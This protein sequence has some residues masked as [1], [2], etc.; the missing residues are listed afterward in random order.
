ML[1]LTIREIRDD[2]FRE[3]GLVLVHEWR[4]VAGLVCAHG[5]VGGGAR[6]IRWPGFAAFRFEDDGR[7]EAFP[8]RQVDSSRIVDLFHRTV[9]PLMLQALGWET[10]HASAVLMPKGLVGFCGECESGKSTIAYSLSRRGYQQEGDDSLVLHM[11]PQ[12]IRA[13]DLPFGV[14]LRPESATFFGFTPDGRQLQDVV[15]ITRNDVDRVSTHPLAALFV[16]SRIPCGEPIV[17]QMAPP[18]AFRALLPHARCFDSESTEDRRRLLEHYLELAATV[19]V[20]DLRFAP[21]LEQLPAVLA[22][23]E[24][25][26]E[27]VLAETV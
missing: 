7:V 2:T 18:A 19:P 11:G 23:I 8:E 12:G 17:E 24:R 15:P 16:P 9:E 4:D 14:R 6:W 3:H 1:H 13:L 5:Y 26:A 21:G 20:Y 27:A 10:L 25:S 22:C